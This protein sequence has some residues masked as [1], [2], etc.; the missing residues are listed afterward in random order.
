VIAAWRKWY[1]EAL[2][3][4]AR[5]SVAGPAPSVTAAVEAAKSRVAAR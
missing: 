2:D 5:L 4:V 3:S 1:A